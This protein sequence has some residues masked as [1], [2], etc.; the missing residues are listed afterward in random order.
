MIAPSFAQAGSCRTVHSWKRI[1][2]LKPSTGFVF[3]LLRSADCPQ[4]TGTWNT[5]K[6]EA[7]GESRCGIRQGFLIEEQGMTYLAEVDRDR[8]LSP[9]QA[10]TCTY[11]MA[12]GPR[13]GQKV[14]SLATEA[15]IAFLTISPFEN[16]QTLEMSQHPDTSTFPEFPECENRFVAAPAER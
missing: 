13:A 11:R 7:T 1:C 14:L 12:L 10:A 15:G 2:P 6:P 4:K 8:A 5:L 16:S 3:K 9:L